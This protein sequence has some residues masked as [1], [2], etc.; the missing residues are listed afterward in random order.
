MKKQHEQNKKQPSRGHVF[1]RTQTQ[2]LPLRAGKLGCSCNTSLVEEKDE[3][4]ERGTDCITETP[5]DLYVIQKRTYFK[6]DSW[7]KVSLDLDIGPL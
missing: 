6:E 4:S 7:M 1:F 3:G 5:G 2:G